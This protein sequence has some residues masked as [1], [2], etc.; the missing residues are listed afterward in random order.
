[1]ATISAIV[2][3]RPKFADSQPPTSVLA[4]DG[5]VPHRR[6]PASKSDG[7]HLWKKTLRGLA[8]LV[9]LG[10]AFGV[11]AV[12][13][14]QMANSRSGTLD[15]ASFYVAGKILR[16][17]QAGRLYDLRLQREIE[18]GISPAGPFFPYDHPPFEAP[19]FAALAGLSYSDALIAWGGLNLAL[20]VLILYLLPRIGR[21]LETTGLLVW[22][23][24]C[25]PLVAG[26]LLL[27]Q[28]SL[29][30]VPGFI[31]AF[32]ALKKQRDCAAG[33]LLGLG[34]FRFEIMLPF[35][36]IFLL[37]QRWK[38]LAGFSVSS[39]VA[40]LASLAVVGWRGLLDYSGVLLEVGR[41]AGSRAD[42]VDAATMPSVR[43]A[44]V[45]VLGHVMPPQFLLPVI[46]LG[47]LALLGW[48]AWEFKSIA[49]PDAPAF[50]L[51]FSLA[52]VAALL[53]SYNLFVH[54]L[55]PLIMIGFLIL[56][57]EANLR[58]EGIVGN[59]RGT[60]LLLLFA[61]VYGVGGAVFHFRDFSV[62]FI[63]LLGLM[64]WLSQELSALRRRPS[65]TNEVG[66][67]AA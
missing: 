8:L 4:A 28:D 46:L 50:A 35:V 24:V 42:S 67:M 16:Q 37:R 60:A 62:V 7:M 58:R 13:L 29:L 45:T 32:L 38:I 53:S 49:R 15:F 6:A 12:Q 52:V 64:I 40:L 14:D 5:A 43:G 34:L 66:E 63:V 31:L 22:L 55:T 17:G 3:D 27:G 21:R 47:T 11:L 26:V 59:R 2:K 65:S 56:G 41:A 18:L 39:S 10:A 20:F 23:A 9:L 61:G 48:A 30:I 1:M 36:F 51:E 33:I 19:L 25:V 54:E 57:Y 44:V